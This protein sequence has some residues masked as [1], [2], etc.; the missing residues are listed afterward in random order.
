MVSVEMIFLYPL[1]L[2]IL[3]LCFLIASFFFSL[4]E[5]SIIAVSKIKLS[6]L[7]AQKARHSENVKYLM[8]HSDQFIVGILIGN[9]FANVAF[10]VIIS[11]ISVHFAGPR[12]G[13]VIATVLSAVVILVF[14]EIL[15]KMIALKNTDRM[16]LAVAPVM[17]AY[18]RAVTPL[19]RV[20]TGITDAMFDALGIKRTKRSSLI[21][22][23]ELRL[24]IEV[25]KEEGVLSEEERRMFHRI[26]EFGDIKVADVMIPRDKMV[27]VSV[28]ATPDQLLD[29]LAEQGHSRLPVYK[30]SIDNVMGIIY[31][32]D[33]LYILRDKG[34]FLLQDIVH[35]AYFIPAQTRV[36]ELLRKF[37]VDKI[38]IAV[39]VD[40]KARALGL[41]TLE[42]LLE[43]IV[44]E[45]EE[46]PYARN[47][48]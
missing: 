1:F 30:G 11:A 22:E 44:G 26:F 9:N 24:M 7:I 19:A 25:G 43:E 34:L 12:L 46:Q 33:L 48:K 5:T 28:S 23:E 32:R 31:A 16:A 37:L 15:P 14:C 10:S 2:F 45:I 35:P 8:T 40:E 18:T 13:V 6:H 42:D 27:A 39:V 29:I 3:L 17:E 21:T 4:S 20:F 38:Q 47:G 36:S 41:V